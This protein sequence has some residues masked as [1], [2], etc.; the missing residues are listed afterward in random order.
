MKLPVPRLSARSIRL[1]VAAAVLLLGAT[2]WGRWWP[3][4]NRWVRATI[5]AQRPAATDEHVQKPA[6]RE[7]VSLKLSPQ[8]LRNLGLTDDYIRPV[9]LETYPRSISV[10]AVVVLRPGRTQIQVATPM[11]GVVTH[12]HAVEGEA[13]KTGTLLFEV[14]LT[15]EDLVNSQTEFLKTLGEL[16]VEEREIARLEKLAES[17][18]IAGRTLLERQYSKDKLDALIGAQREALR[19]HG[20][21]ERQ[22]EQIAAERKLLRE[23]QVIAPS[24]DEHDHDDE[25]RLSTRPPADV[26]FEEPQAEPPAEDDELP[27]LVID[28]LDVH[29]GQSVA[30][31]ERLCVLSDFS[32]LYI[33]GHAFERDAPA[34]SEAL[35]RNWKV[36]ATFAEGR[37]LEGLSL[38]YV[39][40]EID[41]ESRTLRFFVDLPNEI[42]RD[43]VNAE[44]QRFVSWK[45]RPGQRLQLKVP[46]EEWVDQIVLPVEAVAEEGA[47]KY[48]FVQNGKQF[49]RVSVHEMHRDQTHAVIANDGSVF[50]GDKVA[51]RSAHRMLMALKTKSGGGVDAHAGHN[52]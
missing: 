1:F 30:P 7:V 41:P 18:A 43:T 48:V 35:S 25:L 34:I 23:L 14:R 20:L 47:E 10:P 17:G 50:P 28:E 36:A 3:P 44:G 46:V 5:A 38:G 31:G 2:T 32:R 42:V 21:S 4:L 33:E 22:V 8:A 15:H 13:V 37:V 52:H 27:P 51:L 39:A 6:H 19:L 16:G 9:K 12:V 45:Y 11:T 26:I 40:N 24:P 29:K 49:D